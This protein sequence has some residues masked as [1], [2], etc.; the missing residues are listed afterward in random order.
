[1]NEIWSRDSLYLGLTLRVLFII[2]IITTG[3]KLRGQNSQKLIKLINQILGISSYVNHC[4]ISVLI[5]RH[6]YKL[7]NTILP[8]KLTFW[9]GL[10]KGS[11]TKVPFRE[12]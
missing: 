5:L 12:F 9:A 3:V 8:S 11:S 7:K 2:I 10:E 4:Y 6:A 1:M